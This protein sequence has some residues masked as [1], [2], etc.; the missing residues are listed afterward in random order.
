MA[1]RLKTGS[2]AELLA[3]A[4][5]GSFGKRMGR[6]P[7][8]MELRRLEPRLFALLKEAKATDGSGER[9]CANAVWYGYPPY[10]GI[11]ERVTRLVGWFRD[12]PE[13]PVL[14]TAEAYD[15]AYERIYDALPECRDCCCL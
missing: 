9:F 1:G 14:S 7:T 11:K 8:W 3:R 6:R 13:H 5:P 2:G 12:G 4:T 10:P 15:V